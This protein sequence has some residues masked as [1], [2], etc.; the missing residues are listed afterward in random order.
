LDIERVKN[1]KIKD[2]PTIDGTSQKHKI[3][4]TKSM[5]QHNQGK[6]QRDSKAERKHIIYFIKQCFVI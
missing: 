3:C 2:A 4:I 6:S 1:R 5:N